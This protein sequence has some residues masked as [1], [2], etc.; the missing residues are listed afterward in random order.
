MNSLYFEEYANLLE[1]VFSFAYEKKYSLEA[2][3]RRISYSPFFQ[4]LEIEGNPR[5]PIISEG[6]LLHSLFLD[7]PT[8][9]DH[10][11]VYRQCTWA[12]EGYLHIL[13]HCGLP[14][15]AIFLYIP[16]EKMYSYFPLYHEMDVSE[17]LH[18][19]DRLR[20]KRSVFAILLAKYRYSLAEVS[21]KTGIPYQTL[22]SWKKGKRDIAKGAVDNVLK[23]AS[24]FHVRIETIAQLRQAM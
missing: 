19:F 8:D 22:D 12:A 20:E 9:S 15:E 17:L 14:F 11:P 16:I 4:A 18:E 5:V 21:E 7:L 24:F 6:D 13:M 1:R 2:V 10:L 23:L 3:E